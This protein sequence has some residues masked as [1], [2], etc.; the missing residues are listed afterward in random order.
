MPP[1]DMTMPAR[2]SR[3]WSAGTDIETFDFNNLIS[4]VGYTW[5][6]IDATTLADIQADIDATVHRA[7]RGTRRGSRHR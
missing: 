3:R 1:I 5:V 2:P 7:D 4:P 6:N